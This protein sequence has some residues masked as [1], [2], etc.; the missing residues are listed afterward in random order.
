MNIFVQSA[1]P[2][3]FRALIVTYECKNVA[4]SRSGA[5]KLKCRSDNLGLLNTPRLFTALRPVPVSLNMRI[6]LFAY[7]WIKLEYNH[8]NNRDNFVSLA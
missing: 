7:F 1:H 4:L 5:N 2:E 3:R 6:F 8:P